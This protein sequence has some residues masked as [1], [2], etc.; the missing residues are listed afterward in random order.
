MAS[1]GLSIALPTTCVSSKTRLQF[2]FESKLLVLGS[3][4]VKNRKRVSLSARAMGS[5]ASSQKPDSIQGPLSLSIDVSF[6]TLWCS[7]QLKHSNTYFFLFSFLAFPLIH[8]A[9]ID[10]DDHVL[11]LCSTFKAHSYALLPRE[12]R[13]PFRCKNAKTEIQV[14]TRGSR[15]EMIF[16]KLGEFCVATYIY[17]LP[18]ET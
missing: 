5:S 18:L 11:Y 7:D 6:L 17:G 8:L 13:I 14:L 12:R 15:W 1:R 2:V 9:L 4:A 3:P 16:G 10:L